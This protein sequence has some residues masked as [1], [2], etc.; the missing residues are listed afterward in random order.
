MTMSRTTSGRVSK[1]MD[2]FVYNIDEIAEDCYDLYLSDDA[3]Y[4]WEYYGA[5]ENRHVAEETGE[6][7]IWKAETRAIWEGKSYISHDN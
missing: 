2:D 3:G 1:I 7:L 5:F 6:A 4:T